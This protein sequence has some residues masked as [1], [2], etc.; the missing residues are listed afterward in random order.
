VFLA[1]VAGC[2]DGGCINTVQQRVSAPGGRY[3]AVVFERGCGA[4]TGPSGQVAL[5]A[6]NDSLP[7]GR[8]KVFISQD[9][10]RI[11]VVWRTPDS[12]VVTY[13]R[14]ARITKRGAGARS[15]DSIRDE[16]ASAP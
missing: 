12:L 15:G 16:P 11:T 5:L 1:I 14:A 13:D 9:A 7:P 10:P 4:T 2:G 8:G 3:D 6:A